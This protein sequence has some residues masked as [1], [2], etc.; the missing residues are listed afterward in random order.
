[1][2]RMNDDLEMKNRNNSSTHL[3]I[4]NGVSSTK[5]DQPRSNGA[6]REN[7]TISETK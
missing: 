3:A 1:M 4:K 2:Q 6:K 7:S 5:H